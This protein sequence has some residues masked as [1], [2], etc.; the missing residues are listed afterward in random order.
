MCFLRV[1]FFVLGYD[2]TLYFLDSIV[3]GFFLFILIVLVVL[4]LG[5]WEYYF[6][7]DLFLYCWCE[8]EGGDYD[9]FFIGGGN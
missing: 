2:S 7:F 9:R 5:N 6:D 4:K 8:R 1:F 3:I